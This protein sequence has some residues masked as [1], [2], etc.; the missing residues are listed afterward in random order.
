MPPGEPRSLRWSAESLED[1]TAIW[2]YLAED[3]SA[4]VADRQLEAI[5]AASERLRDWPHLGR[6]RW[7]LRRG[8]RSISAPPHLVFYRISDTSVEVVRVL[9]GRRD[10]GAIFKDNP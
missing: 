8:L 7:D 5:L 6:E 3:A 2:R 9:H 4:T 10:L 1:L